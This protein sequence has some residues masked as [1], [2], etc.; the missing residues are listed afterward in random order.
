MRSPRRF[1]RRSPRSQRYRGG[2]EFRVERKFGFAPGENEGDPPYEGPI[3]VYTD[4]DPST[5]GTSQAL[6]ARKGVSRFLVR[7]GK[8]KVKQLCDI[9]TSQDDEFN[10]SFEEGLQYYDRI[11]L[12]LKATAKR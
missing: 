11:T 10:A 9:I 7:I 5:T 2:S 12:T 3:F 4:G 1:S 8:D 6:A